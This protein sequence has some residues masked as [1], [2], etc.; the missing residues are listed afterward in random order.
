MPPSRLVWARGVDGEELRLEVLWDPEAG[1]AFGALP[2][3]EGTRAVPLDPWLAV[4]LDAFLARHQAEVTGL[5]AEVLSRLLDEH[6]EAAAAVRES[7]APAGDPIP[8]VAASL[9]GELA[10]FQW[11]AVRYALRARNTFLADEQGLGK[12][13]EAL[14]TL[15]A[16]EA[17]PAVI[18]C[19]ASM[20]LGRQREAR[21]LATPPLGGCDQR[22]VGRPAPG[23]ITILNY[24]IVA[25]HR[26]ALG[27]PRPRA[28]VIDESHYCKN[29]QRQAHPGR[30][31][32]WRPGRRR[33]P[34]ARPDRHPGA[35]P[36]RRVDR[37]AAGHLRGSRFSAPEP[38][39][40]RQFR[41]PVSEERLHWHLRRRCFVRRLKADVLPQLPAKRQVVVPDHAHQRAPS[42]GSPS[43]T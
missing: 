42:T 39:S 1:A 22:T 35:Q 21:A 28:L 3:A 15:E 40:A 7:R 25:A 30:A 29:P 38:G 12:T 26:Q 13:V 33:R 9:G 32:V 41:G 23:E 6:R 37:S 43:A 16:D 27:P 34:E 17:Y 20:K 14:A 10:P 36:R 5:A 18:I 4:D 31:R 11:A 2:G 8:A 19:P 24:E